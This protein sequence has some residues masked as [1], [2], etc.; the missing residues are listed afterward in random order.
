MRGAS[1][2]PQ[3]DGQAPHPGREMEEED[4]VQVGPGS[5]TWVCPGPCSVGECHGA[6]EIL[7]LHF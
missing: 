3:W 7:A 5:S 6:S 4:E 2:G 1:P